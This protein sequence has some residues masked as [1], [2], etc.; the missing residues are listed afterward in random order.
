MDDGNVRDLP[1]RSLTENERRVLELVE[2]SELPPVPKE[3]LEIIERLTPKQLLL[4]WRPMIVASTP[5]RQTAMMIGR[6]ISTR[7][8]VGTHCL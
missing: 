4:C 8:T 7:P 5:G 3:H 1:P 2:S 6:V